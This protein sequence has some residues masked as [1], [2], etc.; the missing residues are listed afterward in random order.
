MSK[1]PQIQIL[2]E[3]NGYTREEVAKILG[4]SI[5]TY[6]SYEWGNRRPKI[7]RIQQLAKLFKCTTDDIL[8]E[9]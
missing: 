6:N 2:R 8:R 7:E 3:K 5:N 1:L 9:E 4:I